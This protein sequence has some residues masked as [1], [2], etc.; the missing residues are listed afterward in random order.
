MGGMSCFYFIKKHLHQGF[1]RN[2]HMGTS[3]YLETNSALFVQPTKALYN[4]LKIIKLA[5][6]YT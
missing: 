1:S 5:I 3:S 6:R 4:L 2:I